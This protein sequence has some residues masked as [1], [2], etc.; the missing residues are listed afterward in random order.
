MTINYINVLQVEIATVLHKVHKVGMEQIAIL[1]P[2]SAQKTL[3]DRRV[4]EA[5]LS[6]KVAS[7]TESQ[8]KW[9]F[10]YDNTNCGIY[11]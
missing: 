4:K 2:Y 7:I 9:N 11:I 1:T 8:G 10:S 3:I 6:I 5:K